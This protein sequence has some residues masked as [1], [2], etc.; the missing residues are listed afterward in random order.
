MVSF[1]YLNAM[2][3]VIAFIGIIYKRKVSMN[4]RGDGKITDKERELILI[5]LLN[6][7]TKFA[8]VLIIKRIIRM[9]RIMLTQNSL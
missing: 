3:T 4:R 2:S 5:P 1:L 9:T 6:T 7:L 8:A